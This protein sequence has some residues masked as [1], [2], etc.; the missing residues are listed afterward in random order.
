MQQVKTQLNNIESKDILKNLLFVQQRHYKV[1][2]KST[3]LLA[4][5]LTKQQIDERTIYKVRDLQDN[6]I[7][8][9]L[10]DISRSLEMLSE[11]Y[12]LSQN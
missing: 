10:D 12:T 9:D 6:R 4:Y 3:K 11:M 8:Y 1:G 5:R 7:K 2:R